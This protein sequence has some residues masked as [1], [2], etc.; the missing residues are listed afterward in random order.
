MA[1][2]REGEERS[3]KYSG[4]QLDWGLKRLVCG[5]AGVSMRIIM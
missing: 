4:G 2:Q 5:A 1:D 3:R